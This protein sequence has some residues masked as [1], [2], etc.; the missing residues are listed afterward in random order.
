MQRVGIAPG[1]A[2][3]AGTQRLVT[4]TSV[5]VERLSM[6]RQIAGAVPSLNR[7]DGCAYGRGRVP[8][9]RISVGWR[10]G[11]GVAMRQAVECRPKSRKAIDVGR[12]GRL[13]TALLCRAVRITSVATKLRPAGRF[14]APRVRTRTQAADSDGATISVAFQ[15]DNHLHYQIA[16]LRT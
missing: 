5:A 13:Q 4:Y 6:E 1:V 12:P 10:H 14:G 8:A 15:Y 2:A 3:S 16:K 11:A 9:G 7:I